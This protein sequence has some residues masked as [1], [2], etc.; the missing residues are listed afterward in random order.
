MH[1]QFSL[2]GTAFRTIKNAVFPGEC[3]ICKGKAQD[4]IICSFCDMHLDRVAL[5]NRLFSVERDG[6]TLLSAACFDYNDERVSNLVFSLKETTNRELVNYCALRMLSLLGLFN[7]SGKSTVF[8]SIP[9]SY[10]GMYKYGFDQAQILAKRVALLDGKANYRNLLARKGFAK[11]QKKLD[12]QSRKRNVHGKFRLLRVQRLD[13]NFDGNIVIFDDVCTTGSSA[14]ECAKAL[15]KKYIN[16]N[17]YAAFLA[18]TTD[19]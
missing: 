13:K 3:I 5:K 12:A 16:A 7:V 8:T 2:L 18:V 1:K 10:A 14:F 19:K 6:D 4:G 17:I 11:E 15:K 9:R